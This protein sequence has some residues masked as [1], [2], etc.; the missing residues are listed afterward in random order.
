MAS[1]LFATTAMD[2][3]SGNT[4]IPKDTPVLKHDTAH[5]PY[6]TPPTILAQLYPQLITTH[7]LWGL[8]HL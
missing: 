5:F 3:R 8:T 7:S 1:F 2:P 4:S 6:C